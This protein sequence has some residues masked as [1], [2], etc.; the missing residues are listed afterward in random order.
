MNLEAC[1]KKPLERNPVIFAEV[2]G[3]F[4][5]KL[6]K[7]R[8]LDDWSQLKVPYGTPDTWHLSAAENELQETETMAQWSIEFSTTSSA[9]IKLLLNLA[10]FVIE[11]KES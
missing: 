5:T 7:M 8:I 6:W 2:I 11:L 1:L 3:T 10:T 9:C 4:L